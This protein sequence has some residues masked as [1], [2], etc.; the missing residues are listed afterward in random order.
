[1]E[2]STE[3]EAPVNRAESSEGTEQIR[4]DEAEVEQD[5]EMTDTA[6]SVAESTKC[7]EVVIA[8]PDSPDPL[9]CIDD[10]PPAKENAEHLS[11]S[12]KELEVGSTTSSRSSPT[13]LAVPSGQ[14]ID[15]GVLAGHSRAHT[16]QE[17]SETPS[18]KGKSVEKPD[19][20]A[21]HDIVSSD[22]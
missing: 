13:K 3:V 12:M 9:D 21:D 16:E 8:R 11:K 22:R 5:L 7:G 14:E 18:R 6:D 19:K 20:F 1:M 17:A 10:P 4:E 15:P 2:Q